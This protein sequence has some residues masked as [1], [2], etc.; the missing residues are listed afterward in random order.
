VKL[1][2][3]RPALEQAI[4]LALAELDKIAARPEEPSFE[5]T[6]APL[7]RALRGFSRVR[8]VFEVWSG[9]LNTDE[10]QALEREMTPRLAAFH[11][12]IT[13]NQ[14]LFRRIEAVYQSQ[15]LKTLGAEQQRL[16]WKVRDDFVRA[17][18]KLKGKDKARLSEINLQLASLMTRFGQ[19]VLADETDQF[20]VLESE[21][22]LAGLPQSLRDSAAAEA[23]SRKLPGKWV[24]R[25]TRSSIDPFLTCS[26]RRDLREKTWRLFV[27]R[28]D[29]G[30]KTDNKAVITEVLALRAE[31]ARLLGYPTHAHLRL[32]NTMAKTP[33]AVM[34]LLAD[35]W[36]PAKARV[37]QE[38]ADMQALANRSKPKIRIEAWDYAHYSEKVRKQKY[39]LDDGQIKPYLQL[40]KLRDAMFWVAGE[41]FGLSFGRLDGVA[42]FDPGVTV[43][44]VS[45]RPTR[46]PVG[47]YYFDP[48]ARS[49][50]RSGAWMSA[51]RKQE[52]FD[53]E[54]LP[55]VS[56]NCNFLKG[57]PGE[58]VLISWDDARTLFHEF[59]H[60]LHGLLS[61]VSYPTLSGTSV[62]RDYVELP[63]QLLEHWLPTPEVLQRF[64]LHVETGKPIPKALVRRIE[65]AATFNQGFATMEY[66]ASAL[67]DMKLHLSTEARIDPAAFE[68]DTL[69]AH[70]MPREIVMR[71]R[72]PQFLHVFAG[73][74]YSAGYYSYLWADVLTADAF[75]AFSEGKGAYDPEV[76]LRL[77]QQVLSVGNTID[78]GE[79]F[80]RFR[81][82]D[83]TVGPLMR[84]RGFPAPR[85]K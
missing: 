21:A 44:L 43:W 38:V 23:K 15:A 50:K 59:G 16:A 42:V 20:L 54:V 79:G 24:I 74:G 41:L 10:F 34:K 48:F 61:S 58:A 70:G 14:A 29:G 31:R 53:G 60:A 51:Y 81:G 68:R 71:H 66:L 39:D 77:R 17:G 2:H 76:A 28:G 78:P 19:N 27:S 25:N 56:N 1:E 11:D 5:N 63:S 75:E 84:K 7:E 18:A 47:L 45:D 80:R 9:A 12:R 55:I 32:D 64:A 49:G 30:G 65:R 82:R 57:K 62:F 8:A 22:D 85:A 33:E 36:K 26:T 52:R 3:F 83:A 67:I 37:R 13:L 72:T 6:F 4:K 35:V 40:E 69:K 46:Q 73:D